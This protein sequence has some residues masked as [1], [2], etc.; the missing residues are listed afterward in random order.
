MTGDRYQGGVRQFRNKPVVFEAVQVPPEGEVFDDASVRFLSGHDVESCPDGSVLVHNRV[1]SAT[2]RPG[3]WIVLAPSGDLHA[4][5]REV[6]EKTFEPA[7]EPGAT[8]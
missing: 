6:F 7:D 2:A 8:E 5:N 1:V 4:I 3:D